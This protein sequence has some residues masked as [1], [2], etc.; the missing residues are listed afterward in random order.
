MK[1]DERLFRNALGQFATGVC[2]V[3]AAAED[4][5]PVGVTVNSFASVSINPP[6]I[7]WCL[8]TD[9]VVHAAFAAADRFCVNVL[10]ANQRELSDHYADKTRHKLDPESYVN[11]IGGVPLINNAICSITCTVSS[12]YSG[13]DH[14]IILGEIEDIIGQPGEPLIFFQ[15][16][17]RELKS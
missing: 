5:E 7:L 1:L 4:F 11:G 3:T 2:V 8:K 10:A 15:G 17:Y 6:L 14:V 16:K 9:S 12:R 13:G